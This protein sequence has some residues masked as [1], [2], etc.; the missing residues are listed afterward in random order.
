MRRGLSNLRILTI[1][2]IKNS[3]NTEA[4]AASGMLEGA[5]D[6]L[7]QSKIPFITLNSCFWSRPHSKTRFDR[8]S[9]FALSLSTV[10]I[11]FQQI[12]LY[13][14]ELLPFQHEGV[15]FPPGEVSLISGGNEKLL[16]YWLLKSNYL[17]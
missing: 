11:V 7:F 12:L 16:I 4:S 9:A 3:L 10:A 8:N 17:R 15:R 2:S 14:R 6:F 13:S 5:I 1:L